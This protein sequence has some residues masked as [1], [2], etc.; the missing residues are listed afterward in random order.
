MSS[1]H[2]WPEDSADYLDQLPDDWIEES[3]G[4]LRVKKS[5]RRNLP[6]NIH[7]DLDGSIRETGQGATYLKASFRF[8][9]HCGVSYG[10]RQSSDF[11]KLTELSSGGRST[12]TTILSLSLIRQLRKALDLK[13]K[14]RKLLSFTDNRQ[15]ASLQAGHFND[16]VEISLLRSA[17]YRA[18]KEIGELGITHE[19]LTQK[20][21][22][23]L[24]LPIEYYAS[25]PEVRFAQRAETDRALREVLGYRIYR[26][27][28]RGW[29][30][31]S[32]NLEQSGLLTIE[33]AS[34]DEL[35]AAEDVW[36]GK[37]QVLTS[38]APE[39]RIQVA[40]VLLDFMR[41]ELAIKVSYLDPNG[42]ESLRQLSNQ[43]LIAPWA[44]DENEI[45]E[46]SAILFPRRKLAKNEE[47]GGNLYLSPRGGFGQF[48]RRNTTFPEYHEHLTLIETEEII[49]Q[50]LHSLRIAG[51]VEIVV[52]EKD[53]IDHKPGY[54][55]LASGM[56]WKVGDG[57]QAFH[58]PI[59][60]PRIPEG[61]G[62]TNDF[63]VQFYQIDRSGSARY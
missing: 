28:K 61:G 13:P 8:C 33:Y 46:H 49:E 58:D 14:A 24:D 62:K 31:T 3:S 50:I 60:V 18:V 27:L 4:E 53:D 59:R 26:D 19:V 54:Q 44:M 2:P 63:F 10:G 32:P 36:E 38:A 42:Q 22:Q 29:R 23:A 5:Q 37:H 11:A 35:C 25:D 30:L 43:R 39:T 7:V 47:Y 6:K 21:F 20:V 41:R 52:D 45:L 56:I 9:L 51:L 55:L 34:L 48:L 57:T 1:D 40:R 15:D 17:I 16:F 12:D